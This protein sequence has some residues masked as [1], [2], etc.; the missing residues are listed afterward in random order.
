M[1]LGV[2]GRGNSI[3]CS[4]AFTIM[5]NRS[6]LFTSSMVSVGRSS[7]LAS[8]S[9]SSSSFFFLSFLL[10]LSPSL[11]DFLLPPLRMDPRPLAASSTFK[12]LSESLLIRT[13]AKP[14]Q[15]IA[16]PKS[17]PVEPSVPLHNPIRGAKMLC[18]HF[19][20]AI[21]KVNSRVSKFSFWRREFF[22]RTTHFE[23]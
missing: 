17:S 5:A 8:S 9:F 4:L 7:A 15:R 18:T 19:F 12:V 14:Q 1:R 3:P 23:A 2:E 20:L 16:N 6:A 21:Y 22:A 13:M 11:E 10:V